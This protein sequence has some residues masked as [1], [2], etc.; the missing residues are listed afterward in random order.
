MYITC[1]LPSKFW[2]IF[3]DFLIFQKPENPYFKGF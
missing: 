3:Y 1:I 2:V